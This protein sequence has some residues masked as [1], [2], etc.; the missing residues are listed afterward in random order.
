MQ[1][2]TSAAIPRATPGDFEIWTPGNTGNVQSVFVPAIDMLKRDMARALLMPGHLG[3]SPNSTQGS[4]AKA[5][6]AL[7]MFL[8]SITAVQAALR[9]I[10]QHQLINPLVDYNFVTNGVYPT[11]NFVELSSDDAQAICETWSSLVDLDI[12]NVDL[13]DEQHIRSLLR[14]P[15]RETAEDKGEPLSEGGVDPAL[16]R[17]PYRYLKDVAGAFTKNEVRAAMGYPPLPEGG[18]DLLK[19]APPPPAPPAPDG[20]E[21]P[22]GPDGG[23]EDDDAEAEP[24]QE[25]LAMRRPFEDGNGEPPSEPFVEPDDFVVTEQPPLPQP[26]DPSLT[27]PEKRADFAQIVAG[28]DGLEE[29][30]TQQLAAVFRTT[31]YGQISAWLAKPPTLAK[32]PKATV[33]MPATAKSITLAGFKS[34]YRQGRADAKREAAQAP[35]QLAAQ[36]LPTYEPEEALKYLEGKAD[37]VVKGLDAKLTE[38]AR[39]EIMFG[40]RNGHP[41]T[42]TASRMRDAMTPYLGAPDAD[43]KALRP[44]RMLT[45]V[46]TNSTDAYNQ[47]RVIEARRLAQV[48]LVTGMQ[49][50]SVLDSRTTPI[51]RSLHGR[52]YR[53]DGQDLDTM[54][55]PLHHRCRSILLPITLD[56]EVSNDANAAL[57]WATPEEIGAAKRMIPGEFGGSYT[58]TKKTA[59]KPP[60]PAVPELLPAARAAEARAT[61]DLLPRYTRR[62]I[63]KVDGPEVLNPLLVDEEADTLWGYLNAER[64]INVGDFA[65]KGVKQRVALDELISAQSRLGR[66]SLLE[67]VEPGVIRKAAEDREL[68]L[69]I[70]KDGKLVLWDGNH[71]AAAAKLLGDK[72]LEVIVLDVGEAAPAA[73]KV[74]AR[75]PQAAPNLGT[76]TTLLSASKQN[77]F[78]TEVD[79]KALVAKV[80]NNVDGVRNELAVSR[81]AKLAGADDLIVEQRLG[82][83]TVNGKEVDV[84]YSPLIEGEAISDIANPLE[85]VGALIEGSSLE[86]RTRQA[87]FDALVNA[88]DRSIS[89][90]VRTSSG[91]KALDYELS[92]LDRHVVMDGN[93]HLKSAFGEPVG[94]IQGFTIYGDGT[95]VALDMPALRKVA[96]AGEAVAS[97]VAASVGDSVAAVV[98]ERAAILTDLAARKSVTVGEFRAAFEAVAGKA[99]ALE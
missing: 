33:P 17:I 52:C 27:V 85:K 29:R 30:L 61:V 48:G 57:H 82:R 74:A 18:D 55:P 65:T 51:C 91:V 32:A 21:E 2:A 75:T 98:R 10:V 34:G 58:A 88:A 69:V 40:L 37:F 8:L 96:E 25:E 45:T 50:S 5:R 64:K 49:H 9:E 63:P 92:L 59:P 56:V 77:V 94:K 90:Y 19:E 97:E 53:I 3:V 70:R 99:P 60:A 73:A 46:R 71:R 62:G 13:E 83:A 76:L 78:R 67:I 15:R 31:T 1:N 81:A 28:L 54:T 89:N 6:V 47:G 24:A 4:L 38:I 86:D 80:V 93:Q 44:D 36:E 7:D 20:G 12:V 72:D 66:D 41:F 14:F 79:G 35:K 68:P 11:F 43:P 39:Q 95:N 42:E 16:A 84:V 22:E 26:D 23:G 87:A